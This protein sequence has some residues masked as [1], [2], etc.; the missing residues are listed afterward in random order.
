MLDAAR[1]LLAEGMDPATRLV[2]R[3]AGSP[4]DALASTIGTAAGL[5]VREGD[6]AS[7]FRPYESAADITQRMGGLPRHGFS[8]SEPQPAEAA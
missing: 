2:M 6:S 3:H 4:H 1:A 5:T 7:K 8:P